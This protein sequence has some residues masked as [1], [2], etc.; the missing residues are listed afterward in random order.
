MCLNHAHAAR[1]EAIDERLNTRAIAR[2][3]NRVM[4][5]DIRQLLQPGRGGRWKADKQASECSSGESGRQRGVRARRATGA[6]WIG[7]R[8]GS[9]AR[10]RID[11]TYHQFLRGLHAALYSWGVGGFR[12]STAFLR[13]SVVTNSARR[14]VLCKN[15]EP[16]R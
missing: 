14:L 11:R 5:G 3:D 16:M 7:H 8:L 12:K 15:N 9:G 13:K 10:T 4:D 1:P 6:R 2:H